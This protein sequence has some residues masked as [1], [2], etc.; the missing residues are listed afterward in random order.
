MHSIIEAVE[1]GDGGGVGGLLIG[2]GAEGGISLLV[3]G[4]ESGLGRRRSMIVTRWWRGDPASCARSYAS[5]RLSSTSQQTR[6]EATQT[7]ARAERRLRE[8]SVRTRLAVTK[9][10]VRM[11]K[12]MKVGGG[13]GVVLLSDCIRV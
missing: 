9:R 6:T 1:A 11:T 5:V 10:V 7:A 12:L 3:G 13:W 2:K 4:G 8:S